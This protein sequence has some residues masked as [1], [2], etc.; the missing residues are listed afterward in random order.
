MPNTTQSPQLQNLTNPTNEAGGRAPDFEDGV[1]LCLSGGG[2]R[3]MLFHAG[4]LWRL[5]DLSALHKLNR[6]S[7]V[8]GGSLTAAVT[9]LAWDKLQAN[10]G[11]ADA[12]KQ[13]V[14]RPL[15]TLA[16]RTID[17][18][19]VIWGLLVSGSISDRIVAA[20]RK[21]LFGE[22]T[23]Q[24]LPDSPLFVINAT[25]LQSTVL[26]RFSKPYMG[27]YQVGLILNPTTG[28]AMAVA[29]SSAFPPVLSPR[30]LRLDP[31]AFTPDPTATLGHP[32]FQA[33]ATWKPDG[34]AE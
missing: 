32:P 19:S 5:H 12:F 28:I 7:S 21:Y 23:L 31:K 16:S 30:R 17:V 3:A 22:A 26:W 34:A 14:I 29:A 25:S 27:D 15:R 1:G 13:H 9:A 8:S 24:D 10:A 33:S 11:S 18:P 2:Y 20:Y 6:I 4:T